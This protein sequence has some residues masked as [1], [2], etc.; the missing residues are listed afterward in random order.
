LN[1][2]RHRTYLQCLVIGI[3]NDKIDAFNTEFEH[4]V[5]SVAATTAHAYHFDDGWSFCWDFE[6]HHFFGGFIDLIL[7]L[8]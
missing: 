7:L 2:Y 8:G 5:D 3:A 6:L 1:L 4:V